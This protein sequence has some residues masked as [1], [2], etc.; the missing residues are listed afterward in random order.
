MEK[1]TFFI[2]EIA[3]AT[4][5][6]ALGYFAGIVY[7]GSYLSS[8]GISVYE[9]PLEIPLVI[10]NSY[11]VFSSTNF[12][13]LILAFLI[14][15]AFIHTIKDDL[16]PVLVS[17]IKDSAFFSIGVIAV[18]IFIFIIVGS[19]ATSSAHRDAGALW[20]GESASVTFRGPLSKD[21][22]LM[23]KRLYLHFAK[24][25]SLD[26][27]RHVLTSR[28]HTYAFCPSTATSGILFAQELNSGRFTALREVAR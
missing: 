5:P 6:V 9:I 15:S 19:I 25:F 1:S 8:F 12:I 2:L 11:K 13:L 28:T 22:F 21:D 7:I 27:M 17:L 3:A 18:L 20:D 10:S 24:C 23:S 26:Q 16:E 4:V 14:V